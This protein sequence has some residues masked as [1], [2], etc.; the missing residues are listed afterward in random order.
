V[1]VSSSMSNVYE[2]AVMEDGKLRQIGERLQERSGRRLQ[3]PA[4]FDSL[5]DARRLLWKEEQAA[6]MKDEIMSWSTYKAKEEEDEYDPHAE[7]LGNLDVLA[8]V[9]TNANKVDVY[10]WPYDHAEA[11]AGVASFMA[12][13]KFSNMDEV[14][15]ETM[16]ELV[17]HIKSDLAPPKAVAASVKHPRSKAAV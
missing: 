2:V 10:L 14:D 15:A 12:D 6:A 5:S 4:D 17:A 8:D 13:A 3:Y 7:K 16:G 11:W 1:V 9:I